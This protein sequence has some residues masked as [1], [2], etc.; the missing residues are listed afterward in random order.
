VI[1]GLD[2]DTIYD[3]PLVYH[4]Q[5]LDQLIVEKLGLQTKAPDLTEWKQ[6]VTRI[7]D[8][9][10]GVARIAVVGKYTSLVDS[11]K[12]VQEALIHGGIANDVGVEIHWLSS[13]DFEGGR[14]AEEVLDNF[15]GLLIPGGFGVRGVEG[16]TEAV[17]Y[18]RTSG[19]P[20]FGICLGLQVAVIEY[21]RNMC[22]LTESDSTEFARDA[23]NPVICLMDS[24]RQV[25]DMGGTMR[26]G[27]YPCRLR[28]GSR[29]QQAYGTNEISERHRHRYEVNNAY[30]DI[31]AEGGLRFSGVSPDGNLVEM[32]E[33][34]EHPHFIACQFHPELKSRPMRPH[35]LFAAFVRAAVERRMKSNGRS[36]P[37]YIDHTPVSAKS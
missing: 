16:M 11:Y 33:L 35:P 4:Q 3:V 10:N 32:I 27:S 14:S 23:T 24:Q 7:R 13:E 25:T 29:A 34:P 36:E 30:R 37:R 20:F 26:L 22:G 8:P 12:S 1:E 18:A 19:M 6:V 2:V 9:K 17:R 28:P 31:L 15:D 5:K 21:A